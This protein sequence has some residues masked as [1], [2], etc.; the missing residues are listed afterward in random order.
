[1]GRGWGPGGIAGPLLGW[2]ACEGMPRD[3]SLLEIYMAGRWLYWA[4]AWGLCPSWAHRTRRLRGYSGLSREA[5][6][7][8]GWVPGGCWAPARRPLTPP[9]WPQPLLPTPTQQISVASWGQV[10][11]KAGIPR[12][13]GSLATHQTGGQWL[14]GAMGWDFSPAEATVPSQPP[15]YEMVA[16]GRGAILCPQPHLPAPECPLSC[17]PTAAPRSP[18]HPRVASTKTCVTPGTLLLWPLLPVAPPPQASLPRAQQLHVP[19]DQAWAPERPRT[20]CP[21]SSARSAPCWPEV[22]TLFRSSFVLPLMSKHAG[23][24]TLI[25]NSCGV[26]C[27][28]P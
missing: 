25:A 2:W 21:L 15:H 17:S 7:C 4:P 18:I 27:A 14:E 22:P 5:R 11:G 12:A 6:V 1:M 23:K 8:G 3:T 19:R 13:V 26:S 10:A 24:I 20:F 16:E 28:R 9:S